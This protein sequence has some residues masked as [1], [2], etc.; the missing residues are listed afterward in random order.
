MPRKL[1]VLPEADGDLVE[2]FEWYEGREPGLG[3]DFLDEIGHRFESIC[4]NPEQF[5]VAYKSY[6]R[7]LVR[8]L[9]YVIYFRDEG[10]LVAVHA[11]MHSARR[12]SRWRRRLP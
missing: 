1:S 12:P 2:A 5:E 9:P 8:R 3:F 11:V 6:R 4:D 10:E 7:A